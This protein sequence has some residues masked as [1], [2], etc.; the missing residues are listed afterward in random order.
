MNNM[1]LMGM[2]MGGAGANRMLERMFRAV[3][4]VVWDISAGGRTG[5]STKDGIYSIDLGKL[6]EDG[7]EA[8]DAQVTSN[9]F[10]E[11]GFAAPAFAQNTAPSAIN[12]GDMIFSSASN[13]VLGWVVK[14]N[15]KSFKLMKMDGTRSDWTPPKVNMMGL[16]GGVMVVRSLMNMLPGGEGQVNQMGN[17][18]MMLPMMSGMMGGDGEDGA[19]MMKQMMPMILMSQMNNVGGDAAG[20]NNMMMQMMQLQMMSKMMNQLGGGTA[21]PGQK[22]IAGNNKPPFFEGR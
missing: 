19:D 9:P 16:D 10:E 22:Q 18:M 20:S 14:K 2:G 15:E 5:F 3:D 11:F 13:N 6:N 7:T 21:R 12:I 17:F 4:N 1:A 8:P